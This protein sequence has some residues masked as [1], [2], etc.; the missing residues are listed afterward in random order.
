MTKIEWVKDKDGTQG[1]TWNPV[2]GCAP[3]SS[4][5]KNCYVK[6]IAKRFWGDRNFSN[7]QL[8][9][10]RLNVPLKW[11][12]P[13]KIFV[14]SMSDKTHTHFYGSYQTTKKSV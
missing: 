8:H 12:K 11:K 2:T 14:C 5:C 6:S 9:E 4:G 13:R 10:N 7:I 3:I 1:K